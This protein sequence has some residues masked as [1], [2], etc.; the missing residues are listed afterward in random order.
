MGDPLKVLQITDSHLYSDRNAV[1]N[2]VNPFNSLQD[3]LVSALAEYQ[4]D[5]VV[6]T[7]DL[8]DEAIE[9][10]YAMFLEFLQS[11][12]RAPLVCTPGNHDLEVAFHNVC[13][14]EDLQVGEWRITTVD[15]HVDNEVAGHITQPHLELLE[16][17]LHQH[18]GFTLVATHHP[19]VPIGVAWIDAHCI[20]NGEKVMQL[21]AENSHVKG[22]ICG[23]VHQAFE[24]SNKQFE[25]MTTPSTC[26]QFSEDSDT[27]GFSTKTP[28]WRWIF[29]YE[30]GDI[31][32]QVNRLSD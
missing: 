22:L 27:F 10:T 1:K 12:T 5:A 26:W 6:H 14:A 16:R 24:Q 29:L 32:S 4:P 3:V 30:S 9:Q 18:D 15:S 23:H 17:K 13:P 2:G 20:D 28:G 21:C 11:H 31:S 8:A 19:P 7:G 25:L